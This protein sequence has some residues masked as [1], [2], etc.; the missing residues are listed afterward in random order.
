M[1]FLLAW[2]LQNRRVAGS[3]N[4]ASPN[5]RATFGTERFMFLRQLIE[6]KTSTFTYLLADEESGDAVIIDP[7]RETLARDTNLIRELGFRLLYSL[8]THVHADHVT[9]ASE[10]RKQC[11]ATTVAPR[12]GGPACAD[13]P[14]SHGDRIRFG[15]HELEVRATPGHTEGCVSYVLDGGKA[16]FTGDSLMIRACGR[17]DFQSGNPRTLYRS[18]HEQLYSLPDDTIVYPGHDYQGRTSSTI[19]EEKKFNARIAMG[20]TE[21]EFAKIMSELNLDMPAKILDA[22]PA[23]Q[24]CGEIQPSPF[25]VRSGAAAAEVTPGW[26]AA[27]ERSVQLIDVRSPE[28]FDGDLGH[29]PGAMNLPL[30]QL[31]AGVRGWDPQRAI[32]V[33]CRSGRRSLAGAALLGSLGFKRVASMAGGMQLWRE[34]G[35]SSAQVEAK[36]S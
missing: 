17:T 7:V 15:K 2:S 5:L 8:D 32:V 22:V 30:D 20:R 9:A 1:K 19:G 24:H 31:E 3:E 11:G 29:L 27:H 18:I 36:V 35:R 16:V 33:V 34:D 21:D 4:G 10:L 14:V 25:E 23:N 6:S 26:V 28:E 12:Q 13:H